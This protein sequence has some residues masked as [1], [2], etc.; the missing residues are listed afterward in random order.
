MKVSKHVMCSGVPIRRFAFAP[1]WVFRPVNAA[2]HDQGPNGTRRRNGQNK[3]DREDQEKIAHGKIS[4]LNHSSGG[5]ILL[6][7]G[8]GR[9]QR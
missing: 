7:F 6:P 8:M 2:Q 1:R 9:D 5:L 3:N 4:L